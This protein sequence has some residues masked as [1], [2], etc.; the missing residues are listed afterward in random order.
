VVQ[1]D[2]FFSP[3][4]G[5]ARFPSVAAKFISKSN[6][7]DQFRPD[8]ERFLP[9]FHTL[10]EFAVEGSADFQAVTKSHLSLYKSII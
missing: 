9:A 2:S 1:Q 3:E 10:H 4:N 5:F 6:S 8:L 7:F